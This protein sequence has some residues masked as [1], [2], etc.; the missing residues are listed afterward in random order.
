MSGA[1][2]PTTMPG[3]QRELH[4]GAVERPRKRPRHPGQHVHRGRSRRSSSSQSGRSSWWTPRLTPVAASSAG[5]PSNTTRRFSTIRWSRSS[6]TAPSSCDTSSTAASCSRDEVHERVAE[7]RLRLD[8]DAGDRLVEHQQLGFGRQRLGDERA[9]LLA[10]RELAEPLPAEIG[11]RTDSSAW[12]TASRSAARGAATTP[13]WP[14]GPVGHHLLDGGREV[15]RDARAAAARTRRATDHGGRPAR[16]PNSSTEPVSRREQ[17][18]QDAQQRRLPRAVGSGEGGELARAHRD[19]PRRSSTRL[20]RRRRTRRRWP[21]ARLGR[22]P[23]AR[24]RVE[25]DSHYGRSDRRPHTGAARM[26]AVTCQAPTAHAVRT[27]TPT[28]CAAPPP[29]NVGRLWFALALTAVF[30]V[31]EASPRSSPARWRCC[32]TP[33]TWRP[34]AVSHRA[35][36]GRDRG[37]Q[38]GVAARAC[39]TFGLFRLEILA[40]AR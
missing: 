39:R 35:G 31:V 26:A 21:P 22:A 14:V 10:A 16:T 11:E 18:E 4:V 6:A 5:V 15:G 32:P 37:G 2:A 19:A 1:V 38:P 34:T 8:V 12:S 9:L 23:I 36:A 28:P 27:T 29:S 40:V 30:V 7:Q 33:R 20:V 17:P 25:H 13:A 24:P 3:D